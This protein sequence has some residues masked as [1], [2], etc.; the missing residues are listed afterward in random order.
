MERKKLPANLADLRR[1]QQILEV[2][3]RLK[4]Y[5]ISPQLLKTHPNFIKTTLLK[6]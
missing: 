5:S 6:F 3:I 1:K 2:I 4:T